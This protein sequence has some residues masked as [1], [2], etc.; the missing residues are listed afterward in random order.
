MITIPEETLCQLSEYLAGHAGWNYPRERWRDLARGVAGITREAGFEDVDSCVRWLLSGS[1]SNENIDILA[2]HLT[3]GET[4]FVREHAAFQALEDQV[5]KDIIKSRS[6]STR[7][8]RIWTPG[9]CTGEEPYSLA[10]LLDRM[11][12]DLEKWRITIQ[13]TDINRVFLQKARDGVYGEWSFRGTPQWI[14]DKYFTN[15]GKSRWELDRRIRDMVR[16]S[17]LNLKTDVYPGVNESECIDLISCRNVLMYF[18]PEHADRIVERFYQSLSD[19]GWLIVSASE[20]SHISYRQFEAV[21]FPGAVFFR[22]DTTTKPA[23]SLLD[24][25]SEFASVDDEALPA[26][27]PEQTEAECLFESFEFQD[28]EPAIEREKPSQNTDC[29]NPYDTA[30]ELYQQGSYLETAALLEKMLSNSA[31][32][33]DRSMTLLARAYANQGK[34]NEALNWCRTAIS[35][36][37]LNPAAYYLLASILQEQGEI[38]E[39]I[40]SLNRALYLDHEFVIAHFT[41][42]NILL[43]LGRSAESRRRFETAIKLLP[44]YRRDEVLPESEGMTAGQLAEIAT[45]IVSREAF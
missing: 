25:V 24:I 19:P 37:K 26:F 18:V 38:D 23:R 34:L 7:S 32:Q 6:E 12:P 40:S 13:A 30:L 28:I 15:V 22:K 2:R 10:I 35:S 36:D 4:Y 44:N 21:N 11:I 41:L 1:A 29:E 14:K 43:M 33:S 27:E 20:T 8:L 16:F 31:N 5:L 42:G 9:C 17:F 45:A 3:V 39:A